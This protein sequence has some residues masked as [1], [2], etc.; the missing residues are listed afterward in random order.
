MGSLAPRPDRPPVEGTGTS[1]DE[2]FREIDRLTALAEDQSGRQRAETEYAIA[3]RLL[4]T[5]LLKHRRRALE[6]LER[7]ALLAPGFFAPRRLMAATALEMGYEGQARRWTEQLCRAFPGRSL[8][9]RLLGDMEF[10]KARRTLDMPVM[11]KAARAH[12]RAVRVDPSDREARVRL[13]GDLVAIQR[14]GSLD[15]LLAPV[16]DDS[17]WGLPARLLRACGRARRGE[18]EEAWEDFHRAL[19][20]ADPLL[21]EVFFYGREFFQQSRALEDEALRLDP[22]VL[23]AAMARFDPQWKPEDGLDAGKALRDSLVLRMALASYWMRKNPWPTHLSNESEL[24]YWS[25]VVEAELL[26]G[27]PEKGQRGW[28]RAPGR[29]WVRWGRPNTTLYLPASNGSRSDDLAT[30]FFEPGILLPPPTVGVWAWDYRSRWNHFSILFEDRVMNGNWLAHD[31]TARL[32][33]RAQRQQPILLISDQEEHAEPSFRLELSTA[34]FHRP[35]GA[36]TLESYVRLRCPPRRGKLQEGRAGEERFQLEW[37]VYDEHKRRLDYRKWQVGRESRVDRLRQRMGLA[38]TQE[39]ARTWVRAIPADLPPGIYRVAVDLRRE[40]GG[41]H[42]SR[43]LKLVIPRREPGALGLSDLELAS[44]FQPLEGDEGLPPSLVKYAFGILPSPGGVVSASRKTLSVYYEVYNLHKGED[45]AAHFD[46]SYHVYRRKKG[47]EDWILGKGEVEGL[48]PVDPL[49]LRFLQETTTVSGQEHVVK[50]G[51]LD[52]SGLKPGRYVLEVIVEDRVTG[53]IARAWAPF[54][55]AASPDRRP[56][57]GGSPAGR[58]RA[59]KEEGRTQE[60]Q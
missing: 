35:K 14:Y 55:R 21:R 56:T 53:G 50:G 36:T 48:R 51:A 16:V 10:L 2:L 41:G 34:A 5:G 52:V 13:A 23:G 26:F 12:L 40:V 39:D 54:V 3:Q 19:A 59:P 42:L 25:R 33:R 11:E 44:T 57:P 9:W 37:A 24:R 4:A 7:A 29:A 46:V 20:A 22:M 43:Q 32:L 58:S 45:G 6:S 47:S 38:S 18:E 8:P 15:S 31:S 27:R 17:I 28:D 1:R 49:G 60:P 30:F